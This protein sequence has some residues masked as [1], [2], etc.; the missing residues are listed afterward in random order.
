MIQKKRDDLD[1]LEGDDNL[2]DVT[3]YQKKNGFAHAKFLDMHFGKTMKLFGTILRIIQSFGI[4]QIK[5]V[6]RFNAIFKEHPG[7]IIAY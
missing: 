1:V 2:C 5:T 7:K 4:F 6:K 3:A